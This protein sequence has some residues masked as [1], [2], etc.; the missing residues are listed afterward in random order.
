MQKE[1]ENRLT[2]Q[3]NELAA[4]IKKSASTPST[5]TTFV[6][7][8]TGKSVVQVQQRH[9][10]L[11]AVAAETKDRQVRAA[12][13]IVVGLKPSEAMD[14]KT[15]TEKFLQ[16]CGLGDV[17][18]AHVRRLNSSRKSSTA[19]SASPTKSNIIQ[20][21]LSNENDQEEVL[22]KCDRHQVEEYKGVYAREDRTPAQQTE[23][24]D[25]RVLLKKRNDQLVQAGLLD[26]PFRNVIHRRTGEICCIN[27]VK[28]GEEQRYVF[29]SPASA[30]SEF[31]KT[32]T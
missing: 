3:I 2:A 8:L 9:Q 31:R 29:E 7:V 1:T 24:N 26:K 20:V 4:E 13:V 25:K 32:I 19:T 23:F 10:L 15:I 30:L 6:S 5:P 18:V 12:N 22:K 27:V 17:Q 21:S 16:A 14:D 11:N 28:S